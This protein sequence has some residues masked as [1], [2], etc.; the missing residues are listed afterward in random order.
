MAT[1][2]SELTDLIIGYLREHFPKED[3]GILQRLIGAPRG[4][5]Y[6]LKSV[7]EFED[8]KIFSGWL[9][10]RVTAEEDFLW[11]K[12]RG[13]GSQGIFGVRG[14]EVTYLAPDHPEGL[15]HLLRSEGRVSEVSAERLAA[16]C[17]EVLLSR[18][19]AQYTL[20]ASSASLDALIEQSYAES[21]GYR[22][23]RDGWHKLALNICAPHWES[24]DKANHKVEGHLVFFGLL[25]GFQS[26]Q[27]ARISVAIAQDGTVTWSQEIALDQ[28]F[29]Q[30]PM[31]R[32]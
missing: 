9:L 5:S 22:L 29:L 1:T 17:C 25:V 30:V 8:G 23:N 12:L 18:P 3:D 14:M 15:E 31:V 20:L 13:G 19:N 2:R 26:Y 11:K 27:V 7:G 6:A 16:L 21:R 32:R 24:L 28:L 4:Y 10:L